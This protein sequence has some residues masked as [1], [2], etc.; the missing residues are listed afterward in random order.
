M[1]TTSQ[2]D[3]ECAKQ[4]LFVGAAPEEPLVAIAER[5]REE[6]FGVRIVPS[7]A[8]LPAA[9]ATTRHAVIVALAPGHDYADA[10]RAVRCAG[11]ARCRAPVVVLC[12]ECEFSEYYSLMHEG[13]LE[14]F[15][16]SEAPELIAQ[17]V[18]WAAYARTG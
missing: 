5:L 7:A 6:G 13:A 4:V 1:S 8:D 14:F 2:L 18:R 17:G 12:E 9:L 15:E 10:H 3:P 11:A 16:L